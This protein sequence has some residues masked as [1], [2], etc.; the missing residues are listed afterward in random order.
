M[1]GLL[2]H[3]PQEVRSVWSGGDDGSAEQTRALIV[4]AVAASSFAAAVAVAVSAVAASV[5]A[6]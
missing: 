4:A 5:A 3:H 1:W 6:A 2:Q